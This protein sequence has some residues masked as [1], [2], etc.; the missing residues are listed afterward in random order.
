MAVLNVKRNPDDSGVITLDDRYRASGTKT[1]VYTAVVDDPANDTV[2]TVETS[3]LVIQPGNAHPDSVYYRCKN[4]TVKQVSPLLYE[5]TAVFET[6]KYDPGTSGTD[7]PNPLLVPALV[8]YGTYGSEELIDEDVNGQPIAT[9]AGE[10]FQGVTRTL[11]DLQITV[12]KNFGSFVPSSFYLYI[13]SVNSDTFLGF[14]PG[15]VRC[16]GIE[17]REAVQDDWRYW[18]VTCSFLVRKP[19]RVSNAQAWWLRIRHEGLYEKLS[20][21][22][23]AI[24]IRED[25]PDPE[26]N[27]RPKVVQPQYLDA[28]GK[29]L[30]PLGDGTPNWLPFQVYESRSFATMGLV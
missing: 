11:S 16:S 7:T 4:R 2:T 14:P 18:E 6:P 20:P 24:R 29:A 9:K 22:D 28:A 17:A 8:T 15:T 19:Y 27:E 25:E 13:D 1:I 23:G 26:T 5:I 12:V 30:R 3:P 21:G 10:L